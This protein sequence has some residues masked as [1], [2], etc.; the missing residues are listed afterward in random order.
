MKQSRSAQALLT[1][2]LT[3][4]LGGCAEV[5]DLPDD[6]YLDV[7][8]SPWSCVD[9][10][11]ASPPTPSSPTATVR[12]Q[13]CD[14]LSSCTR[15][16]TGVTVQL[17]GKLDVGCLNPL[18]SGITDDG[19]GLVEIEVPTGQTGFDGYIQVITPTYPCYDTARFGEAGMLLCQLA[20]GG[21]DPTAPTA[22]CNVPFHYPVLWFFN[23]PVVEDFTVPI[24]LQLYP[25]TALPSI[26]D[27]A[28]GTLDPTTASV[29]LT[30]VDC[31]GNPA[32]GVTLNVS[33]EM[34]AQPV[35]FRGGVPDTRKLETDASG[36]GGFLTVPPGFVVVGGSTEEIEFVGE[37]GVQTAVPFVTYS[38]L[39]PTS[40]VR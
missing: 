14:F 26:V 28:G 29:F 15:A 39:T 38:I 18:Q 23:P 13:V 3:L 37:V 40:R 30:A 33:E 24:P 19:T 1:C 16:V 4:G 8:S 5:L 7:E 20:P 25:S 35:Y 32:P 6:P 10:P 11:P 21:C 17:C 9:N 31:Q 27:A 22:A 12:F 2:A 36:I 34:R